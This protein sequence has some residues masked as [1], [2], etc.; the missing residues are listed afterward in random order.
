MTDGL[1]ARGRR[2]ALAFGVLLAMLASAPVAGAAPAPLQLNVALGSTASATTE[3]AGTP[4]ANAVD[5]SAETAWCA[6]QWTSTLTVDLGKARRLA[7]FG[8]TLGPQTR[9]ALVNLS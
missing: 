6:N 9:T 3:A 5:G 1:T 2:G 8:M 4:A 7:G